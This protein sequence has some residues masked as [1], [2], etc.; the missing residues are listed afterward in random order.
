MQVYRTEF[1]IFYTDLPKRCATET[2]YT[3]PNRSPVCQPG[4]AYVYKLRNGCAWIYV[5]SYNK[6]GISVHKNSILLRYTYSYLIHYNTDSFMHRS[7]DRSFLNNWAVKCEYKRATGHLKQTATN[8][9]RSV[10][11]TINVRPRT[12]NICSFIC[13][14]VH[15]IATF[16]KIFFALARLHREMDCVKST[17][18]IV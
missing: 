1:H 12:S 3:R 11:M 8:F 13:T 7:E 9:T 14:H 6:Y 18:D 10:K 15:I 17:I 4:H 16:H 5:T 2:S